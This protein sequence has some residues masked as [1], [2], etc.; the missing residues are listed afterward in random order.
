[1]EAEAERLIE[2]EHRE[3][4]EAIA[5]FVKELKGKKIF[6]G[7]GETRILTTAEFYKSIGMELV[8]IKAHNL[9]RFVETC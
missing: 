5:P 4:K 1:M 9:D 6:V 2:Q 8:G 3:L 7:G